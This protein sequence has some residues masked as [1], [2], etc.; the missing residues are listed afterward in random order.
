MCAFDSNSDFEVVN[1]CP[2]NLTMFVFEADE[3]GVIAN[4]VEDIL[5]NDLAIS[6]RSIVFD[7]K[8]NHTFVEF[9]PST[10]AQV[11]YYDQDGTI[12]EATAHKCADISPECGSYANNTVNLI[13][14]DASLITIYL[15]DVQP[16]Q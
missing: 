4:Y 10:D 7:T 12:F 8:G 1:N 9:V 3:S 11:V 13:N 16:L 5:N 14:V 2:Y 15:C 6:Q